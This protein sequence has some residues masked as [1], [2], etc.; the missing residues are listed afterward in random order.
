MSI[1]TISPSEF[2]GNTLKAAAMELFKKC[3]QRDIKISNLCQYT[4]VS[5]WSGMEW[6]AYDAWKE[7]GSWCFLKSE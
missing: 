7:D 1:L 2:L 6:V 4:T 5:V 3:S